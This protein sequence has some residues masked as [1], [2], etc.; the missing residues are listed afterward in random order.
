MYV[1]CA[2]DYYNSYLPAQKK[3]KYAMLLALCIFKAIIIDDVRM[4]ILLLLQK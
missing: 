2:Y 1:L 3:K 4:H